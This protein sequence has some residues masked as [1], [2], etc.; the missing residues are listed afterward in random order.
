V[1]SQSYGNYTVKAIFNGDNKY[2]ACNATGNL[3]V[4]KSDLYIKVTSN[5]KSPKVGEIFTLT[6]KLGNNGP[7]LAENVT[8]TIQLPEGFQI[9][10]ISG[11]GVWTYNAAT[12][13]ITWTLESVPV[14]DPYLYI[15]GLLN[16]AGTFVFSSSLS[17][18]TFTI[19]TE[20]TPLPTNATTKVKAVSNT[21]G[22]QKT[23][24][25]LTGLILAVLAIF[26]SLAYSKT[27]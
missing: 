16:H 15:S 26:G 5:I 6:Y 4:P 17:S 10:G 1:I 20:L 21:I 23:G 27:K 3:H 19:T 8:I 24:M 7:D 25:P 12:N 22:M 18:D 2:Q 9:S 11:D 14:G 13:T